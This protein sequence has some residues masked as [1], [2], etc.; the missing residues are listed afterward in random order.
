MNTELQADLLVVIAV[1][2][3]AFILIRYHKYIF[4]A[5]ATAW[6]WLRKMIGKLF[7][8]LG[9]RER[10]GEEE[11]EY[12]TDVEQ[13]LGEQMREKASITELRAWKKQLRAYQKMPDSREKYLKGFALSALG[14]QLHGA[15]VKPSDTPLEILE[16]AKKFLSHEGYRVAVES[17]N[18][19]AFG[20]REHTPAWPELQTALET[21]RTRKPSK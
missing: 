16:K 10:F 3:V 19:L 9:A 13:V 6:N 14:L 11:N 4:S 7:R 20:A 12:Y 5:F 1:A 18:A 2:L 17:C 15:P 8:G 21:L